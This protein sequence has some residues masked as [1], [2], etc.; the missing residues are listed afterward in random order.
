MSLRLRLLLVL[1]AIYGA[2]G[3]FLTRKALEQVRPRYLESIEESLV[4]TAALLAAGLERDLAGD[5]VETAGLRQVVA[6]AQGRAFEARI[7]TLRKTAVDLRIYVT[8]ATGRVRFDS[9]G[10]DEGRDYSRWNDVARTL[11]GEYGARS[12]R[13][14]EGD[15]STQVIYVAAPV[16][17]GDRIVGVVTVGKPTRGVNEL[18]A[19]ARRRLLLVAGLGGVVVLALLLLVA[20]WVI[21]PLERLTAYARAVRDSRPG[22]LPPLP[23]RTLGDLGAAF[24]E[25]RE[26][27]EGRQHVERYTQALAHEVKAPLAAI[28]GAAELLDEAMPPE[29]RAKFL[30]NIRTESARIQR[31]IERLLELS[32]LEARKELRRTEPLA[33]AGL[34]REAADV[35]RPAGAA[36]GVSVVVRPGPEGTVRGEAVLLR[37]AL[38]NLLQNA[39]EFSPAGGTV[40]LAWATAG[41]RLRFVVEDAGPGVPDYALPRAFER[42]YS[43]P[44]PGTERKSTGLGL[45]LVREIAHLHGGEADLTNRAEGGAR[46]ILELPAA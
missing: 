19:A 18:V 30:A 10:R 37:E 23:G 11:R 2:G 3:W 36:R 33:A 22:P 35:V 5:Q 38:V 44:R 20:A 40:T 42:F 45:A 17:Q 27:L 9:T 41:G 32:S 15:D 28:R 12:T 25:M 4:D 31:I 16:R 13:D 8:D 26:A 6:A 39:V 7:F 24:T 43:L 14:V 34:A 21:T 46:A 29:Q 1:L